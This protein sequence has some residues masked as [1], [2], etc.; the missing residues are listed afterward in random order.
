MKMLILGISALA[1]AW[2]VSRALQSARRDDVVGSDEVKRW[3]AEGGAVPSGPQIGG[4]EP[5]V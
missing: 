5:T 2:L 1:A 3:E 4:S